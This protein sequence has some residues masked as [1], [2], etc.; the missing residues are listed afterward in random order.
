MTRTNPEYTVVVASQDR[1]VTS[2]V[3][4]GWRF[5]EQE[6][7]RFIAT[8]NEKLGE[9]GKYLADKWEYFRMELVEKALTP[10]RDI[11]LIDGPDKHLWG[12]VERSNGQ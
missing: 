9:D 4:Y 8:I 1:F 11:T 7:A 12:L 10:W 6:V 2:N 3:G 5:L